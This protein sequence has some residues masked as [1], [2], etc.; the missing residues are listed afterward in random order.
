[1]AEVQVEAQWLE[2]V[3]V[4]SDAR[5]L[6]EPDAPADVDPK[7]KNHYMDGGTFILDAPDVPPAIWGSGGDILWAEGETLMIA[8]PQ[9]VGKTTL[10]FQV[11][12]ARLGLQKDVLG[13]P[14][15]PTEGKVLYLAMDRP[16]QARR[17]AARLFAKDPR[18]VLA[19]HL[20]FWKGPPP[21]DLAKHVGTMAAMCEE[22]GADTLV[23]DSI[24]DA[25]VGLSDDVVGA[26]WNRARQI[27]M[28]LGINVLELHH[29]RKQGNN[30]GEPNTI[31]DIYG[32]TW[33]TSGVGSVVSLFGDPG[34]PIVSFRHLKQPMNEIGPFKVI[35]DHT[36][37]T[38]AIMQGTDLLDLVKAQGAGGLG[39]VDAAKALFEKPAPTAP[40]RE[41][42]RRK[43][44]R[45]VEQKLL[46]RRDGPSRTSPAV[47]FLAARNAVREVQECL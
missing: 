12:R 19:E 5:D 9:G 40:E 46:V 36:A 33:I 21:V 18:E 7:L 25:A 34:D 14:V 43:L 2:R 20:V 11:V 10:A 26:M 16:A 37:G 22:V 27:V 6:T 32:S 3:T 38:S 44:D 4:E 24:K 41:K 15:V 30:G 17:A 47:Y 8:A 42:A 29:T 23:I 28:E 31:S 13:L 39:V 45:L 35:H 1:M